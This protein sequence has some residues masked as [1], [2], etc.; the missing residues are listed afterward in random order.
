MS[1]H[2]PL[3]PW[4]WTEVSEVV[5]DS[6]RSLD[7]FHASASFFGGYL[8]L[9]GGFRSPDREL[10]SVM[11]WR[12]GSTHWEDVAP[13]PAARRL[14]RTCWCD[15]KLYALG[16]VRGDIT[17]DDG[18]WPLTFTTCYCPRSNTWEQLADMPTGR[19]WFAA[20]SLQGKV[21][22]FGGQPSAGETAIIRAVDVYDPVLESWSTLPAGS[23]LPPQ[24]G[25]TLCVAA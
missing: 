9:V 10:S 12:P 3:V 14:L 18:D 6:F 25:L 24:C 23:S 1:V 16:G 20:A 11:R 15:G 17:R 21:F 2:D 7:R 13:M 4:K 5:N 8:W 22:V 19:I